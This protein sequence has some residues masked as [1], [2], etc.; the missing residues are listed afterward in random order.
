MRVWEG[1]RKVGEVSADEDGGCNHL[2]L[3]ESVF[4][5]GFIIIVITYLMPKANYLGH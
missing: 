2:G 4:A 5:S 1:R 3:M